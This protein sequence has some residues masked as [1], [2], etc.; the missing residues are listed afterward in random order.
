MGFYGEYLALLA[1]EVNKCKK[2]NTLGAFGGAQL[3]A[4]EGGCGFI[5]LLRNNVGGPNTSLKDLIAHGYRL[6]HFKF[7]CSGVLLSN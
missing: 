4:L 6:K 7:L 1:G 3:R 5:Y 2:K